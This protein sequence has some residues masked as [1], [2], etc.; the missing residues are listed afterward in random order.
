MRSRFSRL[1][2]ACLCAS[3]F[4]C[5]AARPPQ[6]TPPP[7]SSPPP[8]Q[9]APSSTRATT[10]DPTAP[11]VRLLATGG[12][13]SNRTGGRLSAEELVKSIPELPR[14]T[15]AEFEQFTNVSSAQLTLE[16]WLNLA[17]RINELYRTD[18][19]LAGV[20]VTSGTDTLEELAYFLNL[21]ATKGPQTSWK[22][23]GWRLIQHHADAGSWSC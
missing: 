4:S 12:T 11:R 13:I 1:V 15:R 10:G 19:E 16:Q 22:D 2:F 7:Q 9:A 6:A 14:Y 8:A 18:P 21:T 5:A 17:R 20:V 3:T 23:S